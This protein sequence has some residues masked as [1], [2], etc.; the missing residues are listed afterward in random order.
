MLQ[1]YPHPPQK[2]QHTKSLTPQFEYMTVQSVIC[3]YLAIRIRGQAF[4]EVGV[5]RNSFL[6]LFLKSAPRPFCTVPPPPP[7]FS[8][9]ATFLS[10]HVMNVLGDTLLKKTPGFLNDI[11]N[12]SDDLGLPTVILSKRAVGCSCSFSVAGRVPLRKKSSLA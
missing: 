11:L 7:P 9:N 6:G 5:L 1:K 12:I 3:G 10:L 4:C 2:S 8:E